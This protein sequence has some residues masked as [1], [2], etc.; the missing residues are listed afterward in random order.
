MVAAMVG[1]LLSFRHA[2]TIRTTRFNTRWMLIDVMHASEQFDWNGKLIL[3]LESREEVT[4]WL[5]NIDKIN[6]SKR[7]LRCSKLCRWAVMLVESRRVEQ[8]LR[9]SHQ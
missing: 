8:C 3:S 5:A 4:W 9:T 7:R 6:G 1:L 2:M